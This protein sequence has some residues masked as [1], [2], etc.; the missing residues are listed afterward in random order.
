MFVR[1]ILALIVA[2]GAVVAGLG[3][4]AGAGAP[5][6]PDLQTLAPTGLRFDT[7]TLGDGK[8]HHVLRFDNTVWNAGPGRLELEGKKRSKIY[9]NV[10]DAA[11]GGTQVERIYIGNDSIY[12]AGHNHY[13]L[14]NFASYVLLAGGAERGRGTKTSFCV[15]DYVN[16]TGQSGAQYTSCGRAIQGLSVGWGDTYRAHLADQWVDLGV[17][18]AGTRPLADGSYTL[19]STANPGNAASRQ[20]L[21][22]ANYGNNEGRTCFTVKSGAIAYC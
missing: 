9:Q 5:L 10:Y 1:T 16:I 4:A 22:E 7:V 8:P 6:Y 11:T 17:A 20:Q 19:I 18:A 2:A 21:R 14:E 13:H 15:F 3:S 12:H